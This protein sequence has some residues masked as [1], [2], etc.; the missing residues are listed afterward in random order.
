MDEPT[1][2]EEL[3]DLAD[4]LLRPRGSLI[5]AEGVHEPFFAYTALA[6]HFDRA[7]QGTKLRAIY[8]RWDQQRIV[9]ELY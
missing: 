5:D 8:E 2:A 3:I 4:I 6:I 9:R 7:P 1:V